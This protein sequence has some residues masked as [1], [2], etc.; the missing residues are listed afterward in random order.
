M[1]IALCCSNLWARAMGPL[2]PGD[3]G[4]TT[5]KGGK[6][7]LHIRKW[8]SPLLGLP[9]IQSRIRAARLLSNGSSVEF[10]QNTD[11]FAKA[12]RAGER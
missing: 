2:A 11:G 8:N 10:T 5:Q 9:P 1:A 6:V 12:S 7:C 3:W 4:V